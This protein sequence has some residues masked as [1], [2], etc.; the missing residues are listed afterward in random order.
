MGI[1]HLDQIAA[2]TPEN[3]DWV[4]ARLAFKG[5]VTREAWVEQARALNS[6][7]A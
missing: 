3:V 7:A 1:F 6:V 5:R 4:D 2:W